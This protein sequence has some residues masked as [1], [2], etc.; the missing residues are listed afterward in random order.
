MFG[1]KK[2]APAEATQPQPEGVAQRNDASI[3]DEYVRSAPSAQ[4]AIDI[5]AGEWS[6]MLPPEVGVTAGIVPLF[7]DPRIHW[8][9][10]QVG[11]VDGLNVLELGPLEGGH[12]AMLDRAGANVTAIE[13][14]TRAYLKCLVVKELLALTHSR[15]LLG[16]FAAYLAD[17][18]E[19]FDLLVASGVLYHAPDPLG[20]LEAIGR[21][22]DRVAI[23]THY[24]EPDVVA[25]NP[26]SA[27]RF[28]A[29]PEP[30]V[31]R[32]RTVTLHPRD[33]L[34]SLQWSGFCGGPETY[35]KWMERDDL[36]AVLTELGYDR[37]SIMSDDLTNPNGAC[38]M[39]CA[40]RSGS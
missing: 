20:L 37:V 40:Q 29:P 3:L 10:E 23:W 12:T 36:L 32:G 30:V 16:D 6:S 15:F 28:H 19:S 14:N 25:A 4:L 26:E 21:V 1:K 11:G 33:Y 2:S 27:R 38:I 22:A 35:A 39:L 7:D 13:A 8:T 9:I 34:E 31:W 17:C 24:F 18:D 5:F